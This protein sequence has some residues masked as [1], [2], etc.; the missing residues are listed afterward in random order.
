MTRSEFDEISTFWELRDFCSAHDLY[1][2]TDDYIDG[3]DLD[4]YIWDEIRDW[5]GGW[6]DLGSCLCSIER[7]YDYY[8]RDGCLYYTGYSNGD[9]TFEDMKQAALEA[10][11]EDDLFDPED[12]DED[13]EEECE[14]H[15]ASDKNENI[16][17]FMLDFA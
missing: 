14:D 10:A 3:D 17:S 1:E 8:Y 12:E 6:E 15:S 11:L 13:D 4:D 7:G 16:D 5:E 9:D 2:I